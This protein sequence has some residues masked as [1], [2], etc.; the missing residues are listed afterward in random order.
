MHCLFL[1][2][3]LGLHPC[4]VRFLFCFSFFFF[5]SLLSIDLAACLPFPLPCFLALFLVFPHSKKKKKKRPC[6]MSL[7]LLQKK[8]K[9]KRKRKEKEKNM[10]LSS[11]LYQSLFLCLS[12]LCSLRPVLCLRSC[13]LPSFPLLFSPPFF[14]FLIHSILASLWLS[15][16]F[17]F[18]VPCFLSVVLPP[19]FLFLIHSIFALPVAF[20]LLLLLCALSLVCRVPSPF[21]FSSHSCGIYI[22]PFCFPALQ[23][24]KKK[25]SL[26]G[27]PCCS[28][29][30]VCSSRVLSVSFVIVYVPGS[31]SCLNEVHAT[32]SSSQLK[33][34]RW[35]PSISSFIHLHLFHSYAPC[36][37]FPP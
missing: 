5:I 2:S 31:A 11:T 26:P 19:P 36:A 9:K 30:L 13:C 35:L 8:K 17:C 27:R 20:F 15:F 4:C 7:P 28:V 33:V 34:L 10:L 14:L 23:K 6:L 18:F 21:S 24:K 1:S 37:H 29:F 25:K 22:T 3:S 16:S 12:F 32:V